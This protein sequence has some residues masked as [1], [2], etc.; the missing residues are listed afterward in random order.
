MAPRHSAKWVLLGL[1]AGLIAMMA[2][3]SAR[4]SNGGVAVHVH[5]VP[6]H[7]SFGFQNR[8]TA[9]FD[10]GLCC[11]PFFDGYDTNN[12]PSVVIINGT[13]YVPAAAPPPV[14]R[15]TIPLQFSRETVHDVEITRGP[16]SE[17]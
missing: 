5:P 10:G 11:E 9:I 13:P 8:N 7:H 17:R 4:A 15:H 1:A 14:R 2:P 12:T 16:A 6:H 3:G